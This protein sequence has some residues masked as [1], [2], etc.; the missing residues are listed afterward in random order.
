MR[1]DSVVG[2]ATGYGLDDRWVR[3]RV[4]VEQ[5]FLILHAVQTG[6]GVHPTPYPPIVPTWQI[7]ASA[8]P[9]LRSASQ[10]LAL[11]A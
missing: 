2:I 4:P 3:V 6:P 8:M 7:P 11:M 10:D 9:L 1:R 5:E